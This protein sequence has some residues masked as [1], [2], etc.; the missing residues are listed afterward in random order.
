M[1]KVNVQEN[2]DIRVLQSQMMDVKG[3]VATILGEIKAINDKLDNKYTTKE[4]FNSFK[5]IAMP[6]TILLTAIITALV[7]FFF[8][9]ISPKQTSGTTTTTT[10]T[11]GATPKAEAK[12]E[13]QAGAEKQ[14]DEQSSG[15]TDIIPLVR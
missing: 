9:N 14:S 15:V 5:R 12:A 11:T 4:E 2:A 8:N 6:A 10:T 7:M 3:D 13:A 1:A